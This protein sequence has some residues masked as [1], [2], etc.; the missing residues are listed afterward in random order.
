MTELRATTPE[1]KVNLETLYDDFMPP[2]SIGP[3]ARYELTVSCRDGDSIPKVHNAGQIIKDPQGRELQVMHN[4]VRVAAGGYYGNIIKRIIETLKGVHE[5]Q[6]ELVFH[7]LLPLVRKNAVMVEFGCYWA[8][9]SI[10]FKTERP[11]G[12]VYCFEPSERHLGVGKRNFEINGIKDY[13]LEAGICGSEKR[14]EWAQRRFADAN[15]TGRIVNIKH[16]VE[17]YGLN[18]IDILHMDVQGAELDVLEEGIDYLQ[19]GLV[20]FLFVSTHHQSI[21]GPP[22]I[23]E[24]CL[25]LL[26]KIGATIIVEHDC[27]ESYSADGLIVAYLGK[28]PVELPDIEISYCRASEGAFRTPAYETE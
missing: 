19:D 21:A 17:E 6:E 25:H 5:P 10:W 11:K 26:K 3:E 27:F 12:S 4:G 15:L 8:F 9:Y 20:K 13:T 28:E 18:E 14:V 24:K 7:K 16:L 22:L 1:G 23:H 2:K